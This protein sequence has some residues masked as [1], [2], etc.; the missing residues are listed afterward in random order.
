MATEQTS[1]E[2]LPQVGLKKV[3]GSPETVRDPGRDI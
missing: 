1:S 2:N 3:E